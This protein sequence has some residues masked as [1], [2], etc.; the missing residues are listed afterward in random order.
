[1]RLPKRQS[2]LLRQQHEPTGPLHMTATALQRLK[3][4][5]ERLQTH[6]R[7][8]AVEDVSRSVQLGDLSENAEY[9]EA[10]SRLARIDGRLF[11]LQE[12]IK[13]AQLIQSNTSQNGQI[14]LGSTVTL[15]NG[16]EQK[17]YYIVGPHETNPE[18]G[19]ISHLSPLG[20]ALVGHIIGD[21]VTVQTPSREI[22]YLILNVI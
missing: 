8:Q 5:I 19:R 16:T 20:S 18:R 15:K 3:D 12:K 14:Q 17:T 11:S 22:A 9:Q 7:P 1:M 13:R 10:K 21:V 4:E 6:D 2:Q